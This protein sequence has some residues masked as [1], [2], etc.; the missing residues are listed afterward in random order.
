MV[1]LSHSVAGLLFSLSSL[2]SFLPFPTPTGAKYD[3]DGQL[4]AAYALFSAPQF[5]VNMRIAG[6]GPKP[7][8]MTE[9]GVC[10]RSE[11]F[12][13]SVVTMDDAFRDALQAK[14]ERVG[15]RLLKFQPWEVVMELCPG[16]R[17]TITQ[18]HTTEAER[19]LWHAD[20]RP[21]YYLDVEVTVLSC[22]D[23]YDGVLGQTY[24]CKY[25]RDGA[26]FG[27]SHEQ[28]E[29]FRLRGGLMSA[30][31]AFAVDALCV[32]IENGGDGSTSVSKKATPEDGLVGSSA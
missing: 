28:E 30:S 26:R 16:Q 17:V 10:F 9:V 19:E 8:F 12:L 29:A 13:F 21:F 5:Q 15:G 6:D 32:A 3:F 27:W 7:H 22:D 23:A 2:S 25:V 24:Q 14:L 18:K 1:I 31:G 4:G 20:G 11:A